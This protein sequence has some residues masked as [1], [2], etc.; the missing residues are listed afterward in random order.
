MKSETPNN[1]PFML[2]CKGCGANLYEG[3]SEPCDYCGRIEWPVLDMHER[4]TMD[5]EYVTL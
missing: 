4:P 3:D 2:G 5:P 1:K